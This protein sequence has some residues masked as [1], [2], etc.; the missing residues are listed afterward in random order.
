MPDQIQA[1]LLALSEPRSGELGT[2]EDMDCNA[3]LL[4][5][6]H[7]H[8]ATRSGEPHVQSHRLALSCRGEQAHPCCSRWEVFWDYLITWNAMPKH[9]GIPLLAFLETLSGEPSCLRSSSLLFCVTR[10]VSM[11]LTLSALCSG[12]S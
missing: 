7:A 11:L 4:C 2:P 3:C 8:R 9:A 6:L 5:C 12:M 10:S 1:C